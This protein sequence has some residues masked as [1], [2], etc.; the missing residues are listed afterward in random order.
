[1]KKLLFVVIAAVAV[2]YTQAQKLNQDTLAKYSK[3]AEQTKVFNKIVADIHLDAMQSEKFSEVSSFY[4]DKAIAIVKETKT[5][6]C[7]KL[8]MLKQTLKEYMSQIKQ[9]LSTEQLAML[10]GEREKY[11]FG[12]RFVTF[13][14]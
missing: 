5:A 4:T 2:N 12:R 13:N 6:P 11:H 1:M 7:D 3:K 10:K 14:D 9:V 8:G